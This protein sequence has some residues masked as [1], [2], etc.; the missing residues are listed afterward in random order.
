MK[1]LI[2]HHEYFS[3]IIN[4]LLNIAISTLTN[5]ICYKLQYGKCIT[6]LY[7][8][9]KITSRDSFNITLNDQRHYYRNNFKEEND[10]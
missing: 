7:W 1:N 6:K 5:K 9:I 3:Y 2:K 10:N 8:K 4:L